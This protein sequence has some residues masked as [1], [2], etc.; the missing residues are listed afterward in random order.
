MSVNSNSILFIDVETSGYDKYNLLDRSGDYKFQIVSIGLIVAST[1]SPNWKIRDTL[2]LE[3]QWNGTSSWDPVAEKVH[4]LSKAD[5]DAN[6]I[7]EEEAFD[8]I[9]HFIMTHFDTNSTILLG[10]HN[11]GTFDRHFLLR[12]FD[13]YD[14]TI[15]LSGRT[16]DTYS[17][18]KVLY[19]C[20]NSTE[21]FELMGN[22]RNAHNALEDAKLAY[23]IV[24]LSSQLAERLNE[25]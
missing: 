2:Y 14:C 6:G 22:T 5:L 1:K 8:Q 17:I 4:G 23:N 19:G 21:L 25:L 11:V 15:N 7:P 10:G 3:I 20:D 18:G 13:K 16:I 24:R 12:L 9:C